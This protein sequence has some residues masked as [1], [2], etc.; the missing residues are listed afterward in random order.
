[1]PEWKIRE[2]GNNVTVVH[3]LRAEAPKWTFD[4]A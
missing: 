3:L 4:S 1:M 2:I